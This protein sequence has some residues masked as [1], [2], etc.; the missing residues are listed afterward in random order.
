MLLQIT[1]T[2][3]YGCRHCMQN[4]T[5]EPQ[6]MTIPLFNNVMKFIEVLGARMICVTGGEPTDHP[7]WDQFVFALCARLERE[8]FSIV[9]LATNGKWLGDRTIEGKIVDLFE[10]FHNFYVQVT[11]IEDL[12][13]NH[14]QTIEAYNA[15]IDSLPEKWVGNCSLTTELTTIVSLGRAATDPEYSQ[16]AAN[17]PRQMT[18]CFA[19]TLTAA[20]TNLVDAHRIL[21]AKAKFCHPLVDWRGGVHWSE[22]WLCPPFGTIPDN[23]D[24]DHFAFAELVRA[25]HSWRP[26]GKCADYQKLLNNHTSVY[27]AGKRMLGIPSENKV[28]K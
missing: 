8:P 14:E 17:N 16:I 13:P 20:Q 24:F 9:H 26:C 23:G 4:S 1:N 28:I 21:E 3:T 7:E 10:Q 6:H 27:E 2:C 11:T 22:S 12:Y 18:S 25:A 19:S 5:P 15:F